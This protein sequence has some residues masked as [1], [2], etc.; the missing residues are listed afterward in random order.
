LIVE[1]I[2]RARL[3]PNYCLPGTNPQITEYWSTN[4]ELIP[5]FIIERIVKAG[6]MES[7]KATGTPAFNNGERPQMNAKPFV[8]AAR[9]PAQT[10]LLPIAPAGS[11]LRFMSEP[12]GKRLY[13][14]FAN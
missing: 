10:W 2:G 11:G 4:W 3:L 8:A 9:Q 6:L 12:H 14:N 13:T 7:R 1:F 5:R